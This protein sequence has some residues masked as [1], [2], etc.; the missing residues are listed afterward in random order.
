MSLLA[1]ASGFAKRGMQ[2]KDE[3]DEL[4]NKIE[5]Q[6]KMMNFKHAA[7][8]RSAAIRRKR[9]KENR[10]KDSFKLWRS[11]AGPDVTQEQ[12][13][14][15][16]DQPEQLQQLAMDQVVG[17][18]DFTTL[19]KG[20]Q[21]TGEDGQPPENALM[22]DKDVLFK[23][24]Q[25]QAETQAE[26]EFNLINKWFNAT[27]AGDM[28][29]AAKIKGQLQGLQDIAMKDKRKEL[30]YSHLNNLLTIS[31]DTPAMVYHNGN[32]IKN[33]VFE[34]DSSNA[35][36]TKA[37]INKVNSFIDAI[38]EDRRDEE[39]VETYVRQYTL[40]K[41]DAME[42]YYNA[43]KEEVVLPQNKW[44]INM[45][46]T[47]NTNLKTWLGNALM[48]DK[49]YNKKIVLEQGNLRPILL[50]IGADGTVYLNNGTSGEWTMEEF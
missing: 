40:N 2:K 15:I 29:S 48:D 26:L 10:L 39:T 43:L 45:K 34:N 37:Y 3:R 33:T 28:E 20:Y 41:Q 31:S 7:E 4:N 18:A 27:E 19:I 30:T 47:R 23:K 9:E 24:K 12:I 32:W 16:A 36:Y 8:Q 6:K 13:E 38:P 21:T 17:G 5:F 42:N 49:L 14:W 46:A 35:R 50:T 22:W 11:L 1:F 44:D 25:K